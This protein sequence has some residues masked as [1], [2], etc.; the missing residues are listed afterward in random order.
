MS[1]PHRPRV[2]AI[3]LSVLVGLPLGCRREPL[4]PPPPASTPAGAAQ[5]LY[6]GLGERQP[7]LVWD[8]LPSSYQ[9]ELEQLVRGFAQQ[10]DEPTWNRCFATARKGV[11]LLREQRAYVLDCP[12]IGWVLKLADP[13]QA[14]PGWN[15]SVGVLEALVNSDLAD[16]GKLRAFD[17]R[18]F[19]AGPG[20]ALLANLAKLSALR[21]EPELARALDAAAQAKIELLSSGA[22][23]AIVRVSLPER[24]PVEQIWTRIDGQWVSQDFE[25][26]WK[27]WMPKLHGWADGLAST[28]SPK[29]KGALLQVLPMV[30][31]LLDRMLAA[32]TQAEFNDAVKDGT[33]TL[34]GALTGLAISAG[35]P[36]FASE[37][38]R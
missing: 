21:E 3:A 15:A 30:D 5:R 17:A 24:E 18:A 28:S 20:R 35:L 32:K 13:A 7:D 26:A 36:D 19:C 27:E 37:E 16:L 2:C 33:L 11:E 34:G 38:D 9:R 31:G 8:G 6:Q 23:R 14:E 4:A 12:G 29:L 25:T 1:P 22:E 10:M